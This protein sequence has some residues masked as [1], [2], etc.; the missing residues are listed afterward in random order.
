MPRRP[1][2]VAVALVLLNA[3]IAISIVLFG[4]FG[5]L[6]AR[7]L[8]T[9]ATVTCSAFAVLVNATGSGSRLG[10]VARRVGLALSPLAG[11]LVVAMIWTGEWSWGLMQWVLS[12]LTLAIGATVVGVADT[13]S[14][15]PQDRQLVQA[16]GALGSALTL[17]VVS[18][19]WIEPDSSAPLRLFTTGVV[20]YAALILILL[21]RSRSGE[22]SPSASDRAGD[23]VA[24]AVH[25]VHQL[26]RRRGVTIAVAES[27]TAGAVA[28][29]L[30][31][32]SGASGFL[33]G[34]V[35]AYDI[36]AKVNVL[37]VDRSEAE[38]TECVSETVAR[39]MASGVRQLFGS[40]YG[41]AATGWAEPT[42]GKTV[43]DPRAAIAVSWRDGERSQWVRRPGESRGQMIDRVVMEVLQLLVDVMGDETGTFGPVD[44]DGG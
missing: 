38:A 31:R 30:G 35:V 39:E 1:A 16:T 17:V 21:V 26:A 37:G 33:R 14:A 43:A 23:G 12:L 20:A 6:Q 2:R 18:F 19:I 10:D 22:A 42:P 7:I 4:G 29:A 15:R 11:G 34:G 41:I 8:G 32:E 13:I 5:Q 27:L 40:D 36:D 44:E 3:A 25:P 24:L 9:S 28:A